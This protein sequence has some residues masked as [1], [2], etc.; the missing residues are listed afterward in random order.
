MRTKDMFSTRNFAKPIHAKIGVATTMQEATP[1]VGNLL[2]KCVP[3]I[4][5]SILIKRIY[6]LIHKFPRS[7]SKRFVLILTAFRRFWNKYIC[8]DPYYR[9]V[10]VA[11]IQRLLAR[12]ML[13]IAYF[14]HY[15][16][17]GHLLSIIDICNPEET[18][19]YARSASVVINC[20]T[21]LKCWPCRGRPPSCHYQTFFTEYADSMTFAW[22]LDVSQLKNG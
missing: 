2:S 21:G 9:M 19:C 4:W 3:L 10:V 12:W 6:G 16:Y 7:I 8:F 5:D 11:S 14:C 22:I 18:S 20:N 15:Y 13:D 17:Y 1:N